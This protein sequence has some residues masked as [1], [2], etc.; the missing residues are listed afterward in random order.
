[1]NKDPIYNDIRFVYTRFFNDVDFNFDVV[2]QFIFEKVLPLNPSLVID[3]GCGK[4]SYKSKIPNLIGFDPGDYIGADFKST[5]LEAN[6][7]PESADVI[8]MLGSV[9]FIGKPYIRK[10]ISKLVSWIK[11]NGLI[12]GRANLDTEYF[13]QFLSYANPLKQVPW[14]KEFLYQITEEFNLE[15]DTEPFLRPWRNIERINRVSKLVP[16]KVDLYKM[17]WIWKKP[18]V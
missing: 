8:L 10:N 15:F 9:Q 5:I 16:G 13:R 14:S 18:N 2:N 3:A 17:Y 1:M 6:F 7:E 12:I 11:P 4:N